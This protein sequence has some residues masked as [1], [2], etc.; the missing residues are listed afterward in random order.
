VCFA[1]VIFS[2]WEGWGNAKMFYLKNIFSVGR[3]IAK[4]LKVVTI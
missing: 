1:K 2:F 4:M 3:A